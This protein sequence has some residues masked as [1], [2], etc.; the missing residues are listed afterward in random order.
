[1]TEFVCT[2]TVPGATVK[3]GDVIIGELFMKEFDDS[4]VKYIR[5]TE[6]S[7]ILFDGSPRWV[8]GDEV[9]LIG[10]LF[11]WKIVK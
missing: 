10:L 8:V 6:D 11:G 9:P 2:R 3:E 1:M 5:V 7:T 4:D